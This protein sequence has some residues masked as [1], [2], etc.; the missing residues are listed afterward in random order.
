MNEIKMVNITKCPC[1]N[2]FRFGLLLSQAPESAWQEIEEKD[3]QERKRDSE[4]AVGEIG[5]YGQCQR[6]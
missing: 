6:S 5:V 3:M 1:F 2:I 4:M